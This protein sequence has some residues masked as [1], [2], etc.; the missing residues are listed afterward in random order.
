MIVM[1]FGGTSVQDSSAINRLIEI[2]R[3]KIHL[4][5]VIV[6]SALSKVTDTLQE[7]AN[8]SHRGDLTRALSLTDTFINGFGVIKR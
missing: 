3:N 6:V 7:I 5:P 8:L 4:H 2:A 1:K